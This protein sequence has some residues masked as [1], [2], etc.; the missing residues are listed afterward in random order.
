MTESGKRAGRDRVQVAKRRRTADEFVR[1]PRNQTAE[2]RMFGDPRDPKAELLIFKCPSC[3]DR[4]T[5]RLVM[6]NLEVK[7]GHAKP[8]EEGRTA[9]PG[10]VGVLLHVTR[11]QVLQILRE[12]D[13]K[14]VLRSS[15]SEGMA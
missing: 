5:S 6:V 3:P 2:L 1:I 10:K 4:T 7:L 15:Q 12:L 9:W 13:T 11:D 14:P 8:A